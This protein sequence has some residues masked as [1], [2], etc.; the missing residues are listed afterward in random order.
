M[1]SLYL[2]RSPLLKRKKRLG[3]FKTSHKVLGKLNFELAP[4]HGPISESEIV[5]VSTSFSRHKKTIAVIL[6]KLPFKRKPE[7]IVDSNLQD[8]DLQATVEY[9]SKISNR[10]HHLVLLVPREIRVKLIA[11]FLLDKE[12]IP[13]G[14]TKFISLD[15][16]FWNEILPEK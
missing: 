16:K 4:S 3:I 9:L 5:I 12:D 8:K 7:V 2:V 10:Y 14:T 1:K 11:Y 6:K 13:V 15:I